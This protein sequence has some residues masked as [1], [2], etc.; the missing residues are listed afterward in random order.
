[1]SKAINDGAPNAR[2]HADDSN[3]PRSAWPTWYYCTACQRAFNS[4]GIRQHVHTHWKDWRKAD[5]GSL[6]AHLDAN[7]GPLASSVP[8][9]TEGPYPASHPPLVCRRL[10]VGRRTQLASRSSGGGKPREVKGGGCRS[11]QSRSGAC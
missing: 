6:K 2:A 3:L 8:G 10:G 5:R 4:R 7:Y 11:P 9:S 1:M